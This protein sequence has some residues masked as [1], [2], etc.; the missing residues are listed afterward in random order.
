MSE[1]IVV[2]LCWIDEEQTMPG[3]YVVEFFP[4]LFQARVYD[5][6]PPYERVLGVFV[7]SKA[8][9]KAIYHHEQKWWRDLGL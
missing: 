2:V 9:C 5:Q 7:D 3:D 1:N 6:A 4:G 8:A